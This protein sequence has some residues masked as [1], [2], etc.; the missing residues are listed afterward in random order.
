MTSSVKSEV[1]NVS[2]RRQRTI[3]PRP[4]ATNIT[5]SVK[6]GRAAFELCERTDRQTHRQ[7][8]IQTDILITILCNLTGQS[9]KGLQEVK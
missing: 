4:Q 5:N 7:T 3:E 9:N 2:Q 8:N 6:L 1:H